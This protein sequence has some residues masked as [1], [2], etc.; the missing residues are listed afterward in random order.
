MPRKRYKARTFSRKRTTRLM[1]QI[2]RIAKRKG[3]P[4][5]ITPDEVRE[6]K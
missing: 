4:C 5:T 3:L 2:G 6:E 1:K